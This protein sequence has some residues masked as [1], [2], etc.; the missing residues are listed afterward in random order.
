[1]SRTIEFQLVNGRFSP[2]EAQPI[3]SQMASAK[4]QH[5]AQKMTAHAT[6]EE[7][8]K[9]SETRIKRL[10]EDLREVLRFLREVGQRG[11]RVDV[12]GTIVVKEV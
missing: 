4:L 6:T 3:L 2:E 1:M 11:G 10:E 9:A 12:E 5:H 7:D 8:V